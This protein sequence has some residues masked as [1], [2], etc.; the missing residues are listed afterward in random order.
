ME[1]K[2]QVIM[3]NEKEIT[4][5]LA[6]TIESMAGLFTVVAGFSALFEARLPDVSPSEKAMLQ[7]GANYCLSESKKLES[8]SKRILSGFQE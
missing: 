7:N 4:K 6:I 1:A 2:I 5:A 3:N 8:L